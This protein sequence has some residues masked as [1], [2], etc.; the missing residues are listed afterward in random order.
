MFG[1]EQAISYQ[2]SAFRFRPSVSSVPSVVVV[3]SGFWF[4]EET[5]RLGARGW[6]EV[7]VLLH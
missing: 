1:G 2:Q 4:L 5:V 3:I 6:E 7:G